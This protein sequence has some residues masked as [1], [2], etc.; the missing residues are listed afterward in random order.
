MDI[1]GITFV[2]LEADDIATAHAFYH[3][4]IGLPVMQ[5]RPDAV[6]FDTR[7][8]PFALSK[9][10]GRPAA[11]QPGAGVALWFSCG[12]VD[13]AH[14]RMQAQAIPI[15]LPPQDGPFGRHFAFRDPFGH[16]ITVYSPARPT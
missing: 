15:V 6:V 5:R 9:P 12:D 11:A 10:R 1:T 8:I 14:A 16:I 3:E 4:T 13:A 2:G 7:P